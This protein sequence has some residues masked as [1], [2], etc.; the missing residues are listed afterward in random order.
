MIDNYNKLSVG[1]F[2]ELRNMDLLNRDEIDLQV[3]MISILSEMDNEEVLNLPL[4]KYKE[5]ASK[6]SFLTVPPSVNNVCPKK[7]KLDGKEYTVL[8]DIS[9]MK[10]GQYI[11]YQ[12]YLS[13]DDME[14]YLPYILACFI[15]PKGKTYNNGYDINDVVNDVKKYLP[16]EVALNIA[17]FFF[18]KLQN[19]TKATLTFSAWKTRRIMKKAKTKEE[20]EMLESLMEKTQRLKDLVES[21]DGFRMLIQSLKP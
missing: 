15:I 8:D 17:G 9:N 2:Q 21:G 14:K 12:N 11:D 1:K 5:Y 4:D 10:A 3:E 7:I 16:I 18:L 13:N 6:L 20:R 19:L